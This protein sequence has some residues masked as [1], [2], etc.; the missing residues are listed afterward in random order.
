MYLDFVPIFLNLLIILCSTWAVEFPECENVTEPDTF[1]SSYRS[2]AKYV[3]CSDDAS[4]EGECLGGNYFNQAQG[5]CDDPENVKC[6]IVAGADVIS[7]FD[8]KYQILETDVVGKNQNQNHED[9][10]LEETKETEDELELDTDAES[11]DAESDVEVEEE[12]VEN[13]NNNQDHEHIT[14]FTTQHEAATCSGVS[15][16]AVR[17]IPHRESCSAF[18]TCYNGMIIP[19]LCPRYLFFNSE[20]EKCEP[21]LPANC[22][23]RY[24]VRLNCRK[25]VYDYMPHPQK[26]EY[27]YYCLNGFLMILRCPHDFLWHYERRT[28]VHKSLAKCYT[29]SSILMTSQ[30]QVVYRHRN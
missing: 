19:M 16:T 17:H 23:L 22:K 8:D 7:I 29:E 14:M 18:F 6:D 27:Y 3:Y 24:S 12:I 9:D 5:V 30:Q 1:V 2:C 26:C 15:S 4:F 21:Q 13:S 11:D 28:C 25:G 10:V 20:T